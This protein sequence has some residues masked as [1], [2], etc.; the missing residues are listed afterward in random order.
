MVAKR[1]MISVRKYLYRIG[2]LQLRYNAGRVSKTNQSTR[3]YLGPVYVWELN[4]GQACASWYA[5][6]QMIDA[7]MR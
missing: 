3:I 2:R 5:D 7:R 1:I 6:T 4:R